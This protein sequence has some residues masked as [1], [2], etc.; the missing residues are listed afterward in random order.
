VVSLSQLS[1]APE[2]RG[3][4]RRPVLSDLRDSGAIEQDADLVIFIYRPEMYAS[5]LERD[6][7][8]EGVA[9]IILAKH[10]NGPTGTIKLTFLKQHTRFENFSDRAPEGG[11]DA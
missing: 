10:R 4:D 2:Q 11:D 1:R 9:E 8:Q 5:V 7:S 3:G 6:D